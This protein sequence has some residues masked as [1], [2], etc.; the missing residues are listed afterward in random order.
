M[1]A[2]PDS[3]QTLNFQLDRKMTMVNYD[4]H[5]LQDALNDCLSPT[6]FVQA[7]STLIPDLERLAALP[8]GAKFAFELVLKLAGNLNSHGGAAPSTADDSAGFYERLD[9]V[10]VGVVRARVEQGEEWAVSRDVRR[11]EKTAGYLRSYNGVEGYFPR[12]LRVM[13]EEVNA[14]GSGGGGR[15]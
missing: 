7:L 8:G 6:Y 9:A 5:R 13:V 12:S 14:R 1:D 15:A 4:L 3:A 2:L 10:M 11:M